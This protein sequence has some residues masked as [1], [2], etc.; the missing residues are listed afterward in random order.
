MPCLNSQSLCSYWKTS[1]VDC[2]TQDLWTRENHVFCRSQR[3]RS[4]TSAHMF[5]IRPNISSDS[6]ELLDRLSREHYKFTGRTHKNTDTKEEVKQTVVSRG[7]VWGIMNEQG[8]QLLLSYVN[9]KPWLASIL[10]RNSKKTGWRGL[11][12]RRLGL[13]KMTDVWRSKSSRLI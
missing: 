4:L 13:D 9:I 1:G 8:S 11:K 3:N 10:S 5:F 7:F 2:K 12:E 6:A